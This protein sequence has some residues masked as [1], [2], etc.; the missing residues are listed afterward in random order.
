M[1]SLQMLFE[2]YFSA[3]MYK[4]AKYAI[5]DFIHSKIKRPSRLFNTYLH[6]KIVHVPKLGL[7]YAPFFLIRSMVILLPFHK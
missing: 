4:L 5:G 3:R 6:C 2:M 1:C 7:D